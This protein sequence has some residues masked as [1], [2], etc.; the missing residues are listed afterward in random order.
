MVVAYA[1][2]IDLLC[3][4]TPACYH[5]FGWLLPPTHADL[6]VTPVVGATFGS[7]APL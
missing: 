4:T 3:P 1:T 5:F 2:Y 7:L 6:P